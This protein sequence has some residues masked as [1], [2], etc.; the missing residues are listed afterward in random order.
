MKGD[1][2]TYPYVTDP[3]VP[4]PKPIA[5]RDAAIGGFQVLLHTGAFFLNE[6]DISVPSVA[7]ATEWFRHYV[8]NVAI[9]DGGVTGYGWDFSYNKRIVALAD[10][11][12][13]DGLSEEHASEHNARLFYYDGQGRGELYREDHSEERHVQNFDEFFRAYVTTYTS[14]AGQFHEIERYIL[15]DS[16][17]THPFGEHP[18]VEKE[19][20]IFYVLREKNGTRLVFNCRGQMIYILSRN[21]T[22][23]H[24][25]RVT[26]RY[27]G[28]LSP[29]TQNHTLSEIKDT[30]GRAYGVKTVFIH[31]G[32][33]FTN[34]K[35]KV[36]S[37]VFKTPR[38]K[39]ISGMGYEVTH[40]YRDNDSDPTLEKVKIVTGDVT[41]EWKYSYDG[42]HRILEARDPKETARGDTGK[43]YIVNKYEGDRVSTQ[44]L[45][46]M[47]MRFT[48]G[49]PVK[50]TANDGSTKK[51]VLE[52][53]GPYF[54]VK[55]QT[56]RPKDAKYGGPWTT[57]FQHNDDTQVTKIT[58]PKGNG[59]SYNYETKDAPITEGPFLD[60]YERTWVYEHNLSPGNL[61][62]V[63]H[64]SDKPAGPKIT[65]TSSF[66][67][68]YNQTET[69]TDERGA[70]AVHTYDFTKP[71]DRGNPKT[72]QQPL[73]KRPDGSEITRDPEKYTYND[74]GQRVEADF[75]GGRV[76]KYT[77]SDSTGYLEQ[78]E[79]PSHAF[80]SY[81]LYPRGELERESGTDGVIAY[82]RD[83]RGLLTEKTV[84]PDS[85]AVRSTFKYDLNNNVIETHTFVKD[86]LSA[87]GESDAKNLGFKPA[88]VV[89]RK[90]T[91]NYDILNRSTDETTEAGGLIRS[92]VYGYDKMG[93]L[94]RTYSDGLSSSA[95]SIFE[96][97][98]VFDARGQL[99]ESTEAVDTPE[100]TTTKITRDA[101][102]S[103][104]NIE[105]TGGG[106]SST[107]KKS[108]DGLDRLETS[109]SPLGAVTRYEH[110]PGGK[111]AEAEVTGLTKPGGKAATLKRTAMDYDVYGDMIETREDTL[112][113]GEEVTQ[114][115]YDKNRLVER[116]HAP[117]GSDTKFQYDRDNHVTHVIDTLGNDTVTEYNSQ[118]QAWKITQNVTEQ[119]FDSKTGKY[120]EDKREYET[121]KKFDRLGNMV[122]L[123]GPGVR[124]TYFYDSTGQVR[125]VYVPDEGLAVYTYDGLGRRVSI[126]KG[127]IFEKTK[128]TLAGVVSRTESPSSQRSY[129]VDAM[130]RITE[131]TDWLTETKTKIKYD[132]LGREYE[133]TDPIG[134]VVTR[135]L[136]E[137]G[138][139]EEVSVA[140][141]EVTVNVKNQWF[142]NGRAFSDAN[143]GGTKW[144]TYEYD[145]LGRIVKAQ[146]A[147]SEVRLTYDGL[148]RAIE[149]VQILKTDRNAAQ[150]I[151]RRF[152]SEKNWREIDYPE[153]SGKPT[154]RYNFDPLGRVDQVDVAGKAIA[155]YFYTGVDR[156]A[157]RM[158]GNGVQSRYAFNSA[159]QLTQID[160][161]STDPGGE[162]AQTF[163]R[164]TADYEGPHIRNQTD[165]WRISAAGVSRRTLKTHLDY[166][167]NGRVTSA[168]TNVY[169]GTKTP[170]DESDQTSVS[171][172]S[173]AHGRIKSS[174]EYVRDPKTKKIQNIRFD[175]LN[176]EPVSRV[177]SVTT[178]GSAA[179][180]TGKPADSLEAVQ[181]LASDASGSVTKKQKML[182]DSAGNLI[183]DGR[184]VYSYDF[185]SRLIAVRDT[186]EPYKY[187]EWVEFAYDAFDRRIYSK[188][189]HDPI[190]GGGGALSW[191]GQK[192]NRH[193]EWYLYDG[194]RL[195][196]EARIDHPKNVPTPSLLARYFFG[197]KPGER[198]RMDRKP[199][200]EPS[201]KLSTFY[202][203]EDAQG[204]IKLLTTADARPASASNV[205]PPVGSG[206]R[207]ER[208]PED[209]VMIAGTEI[210]MPYSADGTRIDSFAGIVF[211]EEN[212]NPT[213][214][215]RAAH[216]WG[217]Q[218]DDR[219]LKESIASLQNRY[220]TLA[221]TMAALPVA[222]GGAAGYMGGQAMLTA[223]LFGGATTVG[224][225]AG[226][227]WWN[228]RNYS[229][230]SDGPGDFALGAITGVMGGVVSKVAT[231]YVGELLMNYALNTA[232]DTYM[233]SVVN[234]QSLRDSFSEG[235][236]SSISSTAIGFGAARVSEGLHWVGG[237]TA[238][239]FNA[240][241]GEVRP[242]A[243]AMRPA[244]TFDT[245]VAIIK[246]QTNN[247]IRRNET[248]LPSDVVPL[249]KAGKA[250]MQQVLEHLNNGTKVS[251]E[252]ARRI[253]DGTLKV[254]FSRFAEKGAVGVYHGGDV[255]HV[256]SAIA[257][258]DPRT[259]RSFR[260]AE[261][262]LMVASVLVHEGVHYLGGGELTAH[263]AQA[264]FLSKR[265]Y[266][267]FWSSK[268][269]SIDQADIPP[270]NDKM[271]KLM[272]AWEM[273]GLVEIAEVVE[274]YK[275]GEHT[276]ANKKVRA[277]EY[278]SGDAWVMKEGGWAG[279]LEMNSS[280]LRA[281]E[282]KARQ[283]NGKM[284]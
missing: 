93:S 268:G 174:A 199:E 275:Y 122:S 47:P 157:R 11:K 41:R 30:K 226:M 117:N 242:S 48:W 203:H 196:T 210:R 75:G 79:Y 229:L 36:V 10:T 134:T 108:Y 96:T 184:F 58:F 189:D 7:F 224:L 53:K 280:L 144:E 256:N 111:I 22:H 276:E 274:S 17:T 126:A 243:G 103:E 29:L 173:Y 181:S 34:I 281:L 172:S 283:T 129:E 139:K 31:E 193:E 69:S 6:P 138:L 61:T 260:I 15:L 266:D 142:P 155:A 170:D 177:A 78:V 82:K 213:L 119:V 1:R 4:T 237:K 89:D 26:L 97:H 195:I 66:E 162:V 231:G 112:V 42:A 167:D 208:A 51:F 136:S 74:W 150:T 257:R 279:A 223:S 110:E 56:I 201:G 132:G 141:A 180:D 121:T 149:E 194:K 200:D 244:A 99:V 270:L 234:G 261:S 50:V 3:M 192:W 169:L 23:R 32:P 204:V 21:D 8:S 143:Y 250:M 197:A 248:Y 176:Y 94:V 161:A 12:R 147:H 240:L 205:E 88:A 84:D 185:K 269:I 131:I 230:L 118:G 282:D 251:K 39:S 63:T 102:G 86:L 71:G 77:F 216:D 18:N 20:R 49:N 154:V 140:K 264:K 217:R 145:A 80:V 225:N 188:P 235:L 245:D 120:R 24:P 67:H 113:N 133:R 44:M 202:L 227:A 187:K 153:I 37:G 146:S 45:G 135:K 2:I 59:V 178:T 215:Y 64:F 65:A 5:P 127:D 55:S 241:S 191:G 165:S 262:P 249:G 219:V 211:R 13:P 164:S 206:Q 109:T 81:K 186:W 54:V 43:P 95:G 116:V 72:M 247:K 233:G 218:I 236:V 278:A 273:G 28:E 220:F 151:K 190:P 182:H 100:A 238:A 124:Q 60:W 19:E 125:G 175:T 271:L 252:L 92:T 267:I 14:P 40:I 214:N 258:V 156:I 239:K 284:W 104:T 221:L 130:G 87:Q 183:Y 85:A 105:T 228:G 171:F 57:T 46:N 83:G 265:N 38:I 68:L 25:I 232:T 91:T 263:A 152:D 222:A 166:D 76:T 207:P 168:E 115:F 16:D 253:L 106:L 259:G 90:V 255:I 70:K 123:N 98:N 163:W 27:D 101:N 212:G 209:H 272:D 179:A 114:W 73:F 137:G 9:D 35:C 128:Y 277:F 160:V 254:R 62:G 159:M 107:V 52:P 33:V 158:A 148:D 246:K 198:I